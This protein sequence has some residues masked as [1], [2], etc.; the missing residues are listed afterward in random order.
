MEGFR[1]NLKIGFLDNLVD[2]IFSFTEDDASS[3][4]STVNVDNVLHQW[5]DVFVFD[6]H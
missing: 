2:L 5:N 6:V 1:L 4:S 3:V